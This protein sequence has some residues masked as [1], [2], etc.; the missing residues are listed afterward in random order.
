MVP[1]CLQY[2]TANVK[3]QSRRA[4]DLKPHFELLTKLLMLQVR[5]QTF[6]SGTDSSQRNLV[7]LTGQTS[8]QEI[9]QRLDLLSQI[10]L[11]CQ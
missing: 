1:R 4:A 6:V 3:W 10:I 8:N 9:Q 5:K 7:V 11:E 2:P